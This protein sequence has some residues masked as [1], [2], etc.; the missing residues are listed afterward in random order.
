[1]KKSQKIQRINEKMEVAY[2]TCLE[3]LQQR[4]YEI[5][6]KD[7]PERIVATK[8]DGKQMIVFFTEVPKFN[9]KNAQVYISTMNDL[10]IFHS[11]IVYKDS[12]TAFTRKA[13]AKSV[14]MKLE[15]F[16]E[17]DLQY[18]ITKHRLQPTFEKL[19]K[20]EADIFKQKF[21]IK[22]GVMKSDDPIARF[23][24]YNKGDV[25]RV[26]RGVVSKFVTYRLVR[27]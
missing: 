1:M 11:I 20:K 15:L 6:E 5:T 12:V 4:N 9:V 8:P 16:A 24:N 17:R 23:Y 26:T 13:V 21:G 10:N 27:G 18:N 25:I 22:F 2:K 3:M 19:P 7:D 14:E